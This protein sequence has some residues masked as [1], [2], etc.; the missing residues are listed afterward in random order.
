MSYEIVYS[1]QAQGDAKKL[2]KGDLKEQA[3]KLI[4]ILEVDPFQTPPRY[5][6]LAG[7]LK[8]CYSRRINIQHRLV[9]EIFEEQMIVHV[10]RMWTH[11]DD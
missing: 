3:E 9:H 7:S 8:G 2:K 6:S 5:E 10:L 1:H 11:Y 4:R